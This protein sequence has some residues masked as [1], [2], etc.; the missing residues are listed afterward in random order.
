MRLGVSVMKLN[1]LFS[2]V[3]RLKGRKVLGRGL[4][5]GK[6][7]TSG[8]GHKGQK[9]RAGCSVKGFEGGQ[10]SIFTR[11]PK[12]GFKSFT[13]K[14]YEVVNLSVLQRL[15]DEKKID[16]KAVVSKELLAQLGVI[17]SVKSR[18]KVLGHGSLK[19]KMS[20]QCDAISK[21]AAERVSLPES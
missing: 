11:L 10:Q 6:G 9:A 16:K 15:V 2:G 21:T 8:R 13:R 7:K 5:C 14:E 12:R 19:A 3:S 20:I 1:E 17:S 18:V 4:G